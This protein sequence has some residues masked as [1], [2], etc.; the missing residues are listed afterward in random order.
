VQLR[1]LAN[2][3][4]DVSDGLLADLGHICTAS[5]VGAQIFSEQ[6]PVSSLWKDG[7]S[8][9]QVQQWAL[10]G[11]DDYRL[12]FTAAPQYHATIAALDN[13]FCIGKIVAGSGVV[14]LDDNHQS[15]TLPDN[16]YK[17]F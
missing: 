17:H 3:C 5:H 11:G 15:L 1:V 13:V 10:C 8:T 2:S 16:S 12:C 6:L 7:V 14:V 4:I 9:Q